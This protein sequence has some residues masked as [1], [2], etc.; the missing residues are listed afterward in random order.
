MALRGI[1]TQRGM[2]FSDEEFEQ[3]VNSATGELLLLLLLLLLLCCCLLALFI[4]LLTDQGTPL[5]KELLLGVQEM[6]TL[7][8]QHTTTTT[9]TLSQGDA[10]QFQPPSVEQIHAFMVSLFF[11]FF[12]PYL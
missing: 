1:L 9:T 6:M 4:D 3:I 2:D 8:S 10:L 7:K 12:L 5:G 11:L